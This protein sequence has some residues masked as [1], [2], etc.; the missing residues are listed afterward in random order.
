MVDIC[1][2]TFDNYLKRTT[3]EHDPHVDVAPNVIA[4]LCEAESHRA[5]YMAQRA[6]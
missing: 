3:K 1:A 4:S 2:Y 6:N 5:Q